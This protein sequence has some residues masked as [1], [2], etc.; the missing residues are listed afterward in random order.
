MI[1]RS[2][3]RDYPGVNSQLAAVTHFLLA[4]RRFVVAR[5]GTAL[6]VGPADMSLAIVHAG[7]G[8][9]TPQQAA[10]DFM[11]TLVVS[12]APP[13]PAVPQ[14]PTPAATSSATAMGSK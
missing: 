4:H 10:D 5:A 11:A 14:A 2:C 12:L 8:R 7:V 3:N 1:Q 9:L 6:R 13:T